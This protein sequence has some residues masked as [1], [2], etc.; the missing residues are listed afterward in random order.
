MTSAE[1]REL[2]E[3][4]GWTQA[5]LFRELGVS[6]STV[7][8]WVR[9][10][11]NPGGPARRLMRSWLLAARRRSVNANTPEALTSGVP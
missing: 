10:S 5:Q 11:R 4:K 9:G 2:L 8:R 7:S 6:E 3:A 1:I